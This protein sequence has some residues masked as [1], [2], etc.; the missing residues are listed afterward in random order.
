MFLEEETPVQ[1][2]KRLVPQKQTSI[3]KKKRSGESREAV[4]FSHEDNSPVRKVKPT[5]RPRK[6]GSEK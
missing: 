4:R 6:P 3:A 2:V 5:L 1:Q